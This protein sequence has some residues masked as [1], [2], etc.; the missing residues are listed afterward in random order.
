MCGGDN[1]GD[2]MAD[3]WE[4]EHGL[5]PAEWEDRNEVGEGGYTRLEE[6]LNGLRDRRDSFE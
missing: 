6:Y 2:G 4:R 3:A 5:N 1:D